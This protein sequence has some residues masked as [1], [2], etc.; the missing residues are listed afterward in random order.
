MLSEVGIARADGTALP[1][2]TVSSALS[3]ARERAT[4][5][6]DA[7]TPAVSG[8]HMQVAARAG[9]ALQD[10][11]DR[12]SEIEFPAALPGRSASPPPAASPHFP[13]IRQSPNSPAAIQVPAVPISPLYL[14]EA[15]LAAESFVRE[16]ARHCRR[17][18]PLQPP[19][20]KV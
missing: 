1:P 13:E 6:P 16:I 19:W 11:A 2:G 18:D 17:H 4:S 7:H 9:N 10:P 5:H 3:R 12:R 20:M 14:R 8:M 15:K